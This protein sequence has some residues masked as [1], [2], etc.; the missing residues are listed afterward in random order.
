NPVWSPDDRFVVSGVRQGMS[1]TRTDAAGESQLLTRS[2]NA[3]F[4]FSWSTDGKRL[5]FMENN[6]QTGFDIWTLPL[7]RDGVG[8]RAGK[9]ELFL[10]TPF[11]ERHPAFSPDGRWLAYSSNESG[12]FQIYVRAYPAGGGKSQVS[13]AGGVYPAW[14]HA[15][16]ELLFRTMD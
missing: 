8:I 1:R 16:S 7:E 5:A 6:P 3:Q 14:S 2:G 15:G 4:P 11:D 13:S 12:A 10:Q 9:P